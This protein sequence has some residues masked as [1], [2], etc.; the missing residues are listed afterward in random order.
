M[1]SRR[2]C[3]MKSPTD[4]VLFEQYK[5][6]VESAE[7]V[8][9][10]RGEA[11]RFYVTVNT[12]LI[13]TSGYLTTIGKT[14]PVILIS[15]GSIIVSLNW[16]RVITAYQRL[17]SAKFKIIHKME[18]QLPVKLFEEEDRLLKKSKYFALTRLEKVIPWLF[19][20]M[21]AIVLIFAIVNCFKGTL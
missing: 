19:A 17:N 12:V 20:I 2:R 1:L 5:M 11:N 10:K 8:S 18:Q 6:C 13:G 7:Q 15:L 3:M 14:V 4:P 16:E 21:H 9:V